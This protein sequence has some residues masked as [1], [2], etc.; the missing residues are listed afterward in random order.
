MGPRF[1]VWV[2]LVL[3]PLGGW[4]NTH[5]RLEVGGEYCCGSPKFLLRGCRS[6]HS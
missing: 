3:W 2:L 1:L 4:V 5:Q 6:E